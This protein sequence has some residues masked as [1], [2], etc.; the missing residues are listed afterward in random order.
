[1]DD[2][3]L[4]LEIKNVGKNSNSNSGGNSPP[5]GIINPLSSQPLILHQNVA[6]IKAVRQP[7][8]ALGLE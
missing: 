7:M 2:F 4:E 3:V 6:T 8:T 1:L 5:E